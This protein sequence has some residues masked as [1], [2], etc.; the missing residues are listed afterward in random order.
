VT[1]VGVVVPE[2]VEP[3]FVEPELVLPELVEPL[4]VEPELVEPELDELPLDEEP[5]LDDE[6]LLEDEP[7]EDEPLDDDLVP[8]ELLVAVLCEPEALVDEPEL[9][10][11]DELLADGLGELD[12]LE[13]LAVV[14][15]VRLV[16]VP[17]EIAIE[18]AGLAVAALKPYLYEAASTPS[19]ATA[20]MFLVVL[21]TRQ[22]PLREL[23]L[24]GY[25]HDAGSFLHCGS[26]GLGHRCKR[27]TPKPK[28]RSG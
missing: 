26:M 19:E 28:A 13:P 12:E 1:V 5:L 16:L 24:Q 27:L 17:P 15:S 8:V 10:L 22:T 6:P 2:P 23:V 21:L 3:V 14:L 18:P 11:D 7:L 20:K 25:L 4:P 9:L